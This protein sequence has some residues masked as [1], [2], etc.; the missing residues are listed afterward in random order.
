MNRTQQQDQDGFTLI[1]LLVVV[2]IIALLVS[3]LL[4]ALSK[5]RDAAKR[6]VCSANEKAIGMACYSYATE[7]NGELPEAYYINNHIA[8]FAFHLLLESGYLGRQ[9]E[10]IGYGKVWEGTEVW[11]CPGDKDPKVIT[12]TTDL[13]YRWTLPLGQYSYAYSAM[14][15]YRS[16][17][18][19]NGWVPFKH[20]T[21]NIDQHSMPSAV[22]V[23]RDGI[24]SELAFSGDRSTF[25]NNHRNGYNLLL[26]DT[27]VDWVMA[28]DV[29]NYIW[30]PPSSDGFW[31]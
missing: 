6:T 21:Y 3:I 16:E 15:G 19:I 22:A 9:V 26:A 23:L 18:T 11:S 7:N 12:P 17:A 20:N 10:V 2:S 31:H 28:L 1:E 8:R 27:H 30:N 13:Y 4:P 5:A 24:V 14:I 25:G 29:D